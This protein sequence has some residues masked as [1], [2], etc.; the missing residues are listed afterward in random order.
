M[1]PGPVLGHPAQGGATFFE[2]G[3]TDINDWVLPSIFN[4]ASE[5]PDTQEYVAAMTEADPEPPTAAEAANYYD[6]ILVLAEVMRQAG[7]DGTVGSGR[8]AGRHQRWRARPFRVP[9]RRRGDDVPA[10]R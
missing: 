8:G 4:R 2:Q 6:N 9:G 7:I 1:T 5:D 3:G 10:Q